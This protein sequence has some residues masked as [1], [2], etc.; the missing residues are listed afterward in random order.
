MGTNQLSVLIISGGS[1]QGLTVIKGLR[2]S[3]AIRICIADS[4]EENIGKYFADS[5]F[6]IPKVER[7]EEFI[8][9]V[10]SLCERE[11][12]DII[13]PSTDVELH[14]LSCNKDLFTKKGVY[15][16]VFD[17]N[18]LD[19]VRNKRRLH[20]FLKE[21]G[22]PALPLMEIGSGNVD[23]PLIGKPI[24]GWG[25]KNSIILKNF[26]NL[27]EHDKGTLATNYIW[28]PYYD[29]FLEFSVD[30]AIGLDG[31][32][33]NIIQRR[34]IRTSGGFSIISESDNDPHVT[35]I[36]SHYVISDVNPRIG[37]SAVFS[38]GVGENLPLFLCSRHKADIYSPSYDHE[39]AHGVKMIR[40]LDE[41]WI[42]K[43]DRS[44]I[45]GIVF[46]LD[47]TLINQKAWI[48]DKL[49][50]LWKQKRRHLPE[51]ELFLSKALFIIEKGNRGHLF[52]ELGD[53]LNL[54]EDFK[55]DL[56]TS[57]R[58]CIPNECPL[59][60]DVMQSLVELNDMHI[61]LALLTDNP[62]LS[63]KQKVMACHFDDI[64]D[65]IIYSREFD[66]EKPNITV[67]D[68]VSELLH[69]DKSS[70]IMVG[71]NL[72]KDIVGS[73]EAGFLYAYWIVR[74]GTFFNFD[75][76]LFQKISSNKYHYSKVSNLRQVVWSLSEN[77][78]WT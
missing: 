50:I 13:M 66:T 26:D 7:E 25:G 17:L 48:I 18:L 74:D 67:Y 31:S 32:I 76:E 63:Q 4:A 3:D 35:K 72:Y 53:V 24:F 69:V 8:S 14:A 59:Y 29:D 36:N 42:K 46:D 56:I 77:S 22:L 47:D 28:Q 51:K 70:L 6:L 16:A 5:F 43:I 60:H 61:P 20:M 62:P 10:V 65:A 37:T 34:R 23:F 39:T 68:K 41:F 73:M 71:D 57:Y 27:E 75:D 78:R 12:I 21:N 64:F 49:S 33:S 55:N 58:D 54:S 45:G 30:F 40:Y 38:C 44:K 9:A 52:D 2:K 19:T 11:N 15:V 1:F